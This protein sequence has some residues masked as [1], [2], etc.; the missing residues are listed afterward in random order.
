[1]DGI[2]PL[3]QKEVGYSHP[4]APTPLDL[5]FTKHFFHLLKMV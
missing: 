5:S 4:T 1:M 2:E 3:A